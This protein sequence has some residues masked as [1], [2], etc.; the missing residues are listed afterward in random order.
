MYLKNLLHLGVLIGFTVLASACNDDDKS[1]TGPEATVE[2]AQLAPVLKTL[3]DAFADISF[4][5]LLTGGQ[6]IEG[7]QGT[8]TLTATQWTFDQYT[9]DGVI[10]LDG[11]IAVNLLATPITL[12]GDLDL[13]SGNINGEVQ[14]DFTADI[15]GEEPALGGSMTFNGITFTADQ[16]AAAVAALEAASAGG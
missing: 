2:A 10:V 11:D 4:T 15:S 12:T 16:L 13:V 8:L 3:L 1:P 14:V 5:Q 6:V 7:Q 9:S